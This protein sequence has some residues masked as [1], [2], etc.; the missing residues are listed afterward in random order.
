MSVNRTAWA[1][2]VARFARR[3]RVD[4]STETIDE[5]AGHL[6]DLYLAARSRGL[7]AQAARRE[8]WQALETS[9]LLPL[10]RS[11]SFSMVYAFRMALR[12]FRLHRLSPLSPSS[13]WASA[14]APPPSS[15]PSST[16]S[17]SSRCR[18][19][20]RIGWSKFW[21][22]NVEKGLQ[23]D[24]FSPVT[25]L[26]YRLLPVFSGAAAWWRPDVNLVDPGLD[27]RASERSRP[28]ATCSRSSV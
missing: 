22:T 2:D 15:T 12:Q 13:C 11:R 18:I 24:P 10:K 16:R 26:D 23:R 27:P 25:F 14:P 6:E 3:S 19:R 1:T 8:A 5:L 28:A 17:S 7:D 21:D 4:L 9:G 20:R